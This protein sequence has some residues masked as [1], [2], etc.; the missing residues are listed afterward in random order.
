VVV[1]L[2]A[3]EPLGLLK[4]FD[5]RQAGI[6]VGPSGAGVEVRKVVAGSPFARA[7]F[8]VGDRVTA[9]DGQKFS[10]PGQFRRAVR[11]GTMANEDVVFTVRQAGRTLDLAVALTDD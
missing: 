9:A 5:V 8:R 4:L 7:G 1:I 11:R 10:S 2:N 3:R 6:E